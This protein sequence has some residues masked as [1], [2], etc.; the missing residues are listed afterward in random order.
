MEQVVQAAKPD[1][2]D[3][4]NTFHLGTFDAVCGNFTAP[5]GRVSP[6]HSFGVKLFFLCSM[7]YHFIMQ[8]T[9]GTIVDG[10]VVEGKDRV[11]SQ[12]CSV[13]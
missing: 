11:R 8:I 1:G 4:N 6:F 2:L 9:S 7:G 3:E 12:Y 5:S 10:K 13:K